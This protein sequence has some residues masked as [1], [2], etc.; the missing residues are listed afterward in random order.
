MENGHHIGFIGM[1]SGMLVA[2]AL[3]FYTHRLE[4]Q[5]NTIRTAIV[6]G[7]AACV[8]VIITVDIDSIVAFF[9]SPTRNSHSLQQLFTSV[10]IMIIS[11]LC[12][13]ACMVLSVFVHMKYPTIAAVIATVALYPLLMLPVAYF[14]NLSL[15]WYAIITVTITIGAMIGW[16]AKARYA[17]AVER[18]LAGSAL[19]ASLL[20]TFYYLPATISITIGVVFMIIG[21]AVQIP[22]IKK[23]ILETKEEMNE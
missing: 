22:C 6:S 19:G 21:L 1:T 17:F 12:A 8:A 20:A 18:V 5:I 16:I 9:F 11:I 14:F 3:I 2:L 23:S 15:L 7:A 4:R 10:P 13:I